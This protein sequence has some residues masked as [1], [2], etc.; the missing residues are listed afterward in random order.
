MNRSEIIARLGR[1]ADEITQAL[2]DLDAYV[3]ATGDDE[4]DDAGA[5]CHALASL[6]AFEETA[7][8]GQH[9]NA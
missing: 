6:P 8:I 7:T 3:E 1:A 5:I 4:Y 2:R 9:L